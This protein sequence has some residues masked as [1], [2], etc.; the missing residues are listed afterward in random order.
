MVFTYIRVPA[1]N[2][3]SKITETME[4]VALRRVDRKL[5]RLEEVAFQKFD[6]TLL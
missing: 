3:S 6:D 4:I 2:L 5:T 1:K